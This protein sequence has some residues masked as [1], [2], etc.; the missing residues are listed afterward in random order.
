MFGS[1]AEP[2]NIGHAAEKPAIAGLGD[3]QQGKH[4]DIAVE[5]EYL[6]FLAIYV[7]PLR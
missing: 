3:Q 2:D 1:A 6:R 7:C 4:V 5:A